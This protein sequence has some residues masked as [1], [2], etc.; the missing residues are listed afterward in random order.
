MITIG[1]PVWN[2]RDIV[3]LAMESFCRQES[4]LPWELIIYE[5]KHRQACGPDY[6][7]SYTKRLNEAGCVNFSYMTNN[8][9]KALSVKWAALGRQ[10]HKKSKMFCVCD[11]DNYYQKYMIRDAYKAYIEGYD[12]ITDKQ[13]YAYD[14]INK[15]LVKYD[16]P[17]GRT[18]F[19]MCYA[20]NLMRSLPN[21]RKDKMLNSWIFDSCKPKRIKVTNEHAINL[22]TNGFNN[23]T[24]ERGK[25]MKNFEYPF[26]ETNKKLE[27]IV[28]TDIAK[29]LK[30]I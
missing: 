18:G 15:I 28:P 23:I 24:S 29:R 16:K 5:E 3:W 26:Y 27:D 9:K 20:T 13:G 17:E 30:L 4:D 2:S 11:A 7:R 8:K 12:F 6:F 14:F 21:I 19:Q 25:M 22:I 10:A 1:L